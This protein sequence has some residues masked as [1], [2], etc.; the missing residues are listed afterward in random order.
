MDSEI[1]R[2]I[3]EAIQKQKLEEK[4]SGSL[5]LLELRVQ[6]KTHPNEIQ[7]YPRFDGS[8]YSC[9]CPGFEFR[10]TCKHIDLVKIVKET[11]NTNLFE[12]VES[13]EVGEPTPTTDY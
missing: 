7:Y 6:S 1:E 13:G 5:S 4:Y 11:L 3:T 12:E 8:E 9:T 2:A 10:K